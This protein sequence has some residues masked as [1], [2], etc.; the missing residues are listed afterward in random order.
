VTEVIG[1]EGDV[2]ITQDLLL[3][4]IKGED[5]AGRILGQHVSTGIGRPHFWDRA[6]YYG[7][8]SR[9]ATALETMEKRVD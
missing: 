6:R 4:N 5:S 3:Y 7:E 1:M 8:D 9:L 2:I